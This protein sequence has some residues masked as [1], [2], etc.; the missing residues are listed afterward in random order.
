MIGDN[1][2]VIQGFTGSGR[3]R[4]RGE[5]WNAHSDVELQRRTDGAHRQGGRANIVGGAVRLSG[6]RVSC[7]SSL[8]VVVFIVLLLLQLPS[9]CSTSMSAV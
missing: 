9:R 7:L 6:R 8:I 2:E 1:A 5:L 3:V 4:Y